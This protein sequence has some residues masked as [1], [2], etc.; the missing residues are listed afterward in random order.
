MSNKAKVSR[1]AFER[2]EKFRVGIAV[3]LQNVALSGYELVV[4]DVVG[5]P[6]GY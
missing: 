2:P 1:A 6:A 3:D 4:D 5:C